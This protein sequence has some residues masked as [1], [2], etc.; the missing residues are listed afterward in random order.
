MQMI[1][2]AMLKAKFFLFVREPFHLVRL[3]RITFEFYTLPVSFNPLSP[4]KPGMNLGPTRSGSVS[5]PP[6]EAKSW[7]SVPDTT[8]VSPRRAWNP[9]VVTA[10]KPPTAPTSSDNEV[11]H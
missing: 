4:G 5:A 2:P 7:P 6:N 1:M 8:V 11:R 9:I 10:S 3:H